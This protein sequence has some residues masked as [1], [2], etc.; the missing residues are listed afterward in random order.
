MDVIQTSQPLYK[1]LENK[2]YICAQVHSIFNSACNLTSELGLISVIDETKRMNPRALM[3]NDPDW[4]K[5]LQV[6]QTIELI[7]NPQ[8][9][10]LKRNQL[11]IRPQ[12]VRQFSPYLSHK[13]AFTT[14]IK[15]A[16]YND[17]Y[18]H[19]VEMGI[20]PLLCFSDK[21]VMSSTVTYYSAMLSDYFIPK[22]ITF[23][24]ELEKQSLT[25]DLNGFVGFGAGLT[26]SSDDLLV[27]LLSVLDVIEHPYFATL[28]S[29]CLNAVHKTTDVSGVML[30]SAC[31]HQYNQEIVDLYAAVLNGNPIKN[32]IDHLLAIGHSSGH[33]T[34]C[35]IYIGLTFFT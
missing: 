3:V 15:T 23:I 19:Q 13:I 35:G 21:L 27:G 17:L 33:D 18:A 7:F 4:F 26:P 10:G 34:L 2:P 14:Q 28:Q 6:N 5:D 32:Q 12:S 8:Q 24:D 20:Y 25:I 31:D 16:I 30:R 29:A 9:S 1:E 11:I 22:L